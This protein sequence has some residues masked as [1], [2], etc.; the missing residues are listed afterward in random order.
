MSMSRSNVV[1]QIISL[2]YRGAR[3]AEKRVGAGSAQR[4]HEAAARRVFVDISR[5]NKTQRL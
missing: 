2:P 3:E 1:Q 4:P 5:F